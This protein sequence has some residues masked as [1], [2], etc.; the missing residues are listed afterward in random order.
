MTYQTK[1]Y[2]IQGGSTWV[3]KGELEFQES[4]KINDV[5]KWEDLRFPAAGL[6]APGV[7]PPGYDTFKGG[8]NIYWFDKATDESLHLQAQLPHSW[9]PGTALLPHIHWTSTASSTTIVRWGL[10]YVIGDVATAFSTAKFLYVNDN[11][12]GIKYHELALLG[13]IPLTTHIGPSLMLSARLF[14]HASNAA[15]AY[16]A[17][18]GLLEFDL[19]YKVG[20]LGTTSPGHAT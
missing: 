2:R 13:A 14:R 20:S 10:E 5:G 4:G 15:D 8:I 1:N 9:K 7:N 11:P 17:D 3:I 12:K 16:N 18:A 6:K 19:H